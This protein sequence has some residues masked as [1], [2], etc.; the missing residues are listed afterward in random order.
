MSRQLAMVGCLVGV[1][2]VA[3]PAPVVLASRE[4][5]LIRR[6]ARVHPVELA[7]IN[8]RFLVHGSAARGWANIALEQ[9][10]ALLDPGGVPAEPPGGTLRLTDGQRFPGEALSGARPADDVLVWIQSSWLGR[11]EVPLNRIE[12][13]VFSQGASVPA[14]G[15]ADVLLLVN[16]DRV[17]GF[18]SALGDPISVEVLNDGP[19]HTIEIPL[20]RVA[21]VNM[22]TPRRRPS[23]RRVWARDGTVVDVDRL[24]LGDDGLVRLDGLPFVVE[25]GPRQVRLSAV[26]AV[27]FDPDRLVP[28]ATLE[29]LSVQGPATR[30]VVPRPRVLGERAPLALPRVEF[31]GPL[32]VRYPLPERPAYFSGEARLPV[33]ARP[34]GDCELVIRDDEREVFWARLSAQSP[35][36]TI[37]IN[38]G[39]SVL[40]IEIRQG[41]AGPIQN[42]VVLHRAMLLVERPDPS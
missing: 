30:Y 33:M 8:D 18:V 28:F 6:D 23:G 26:L 11:M 5:L 19:G 31:R 16:G 32:T 10:V 37:G 39:G 2:A 12:S 7:E 34:W 36:A 41:S 42:H 15:D 38:V 20:D 17:E 40:T 3:G 25:P 27:L 24:A 13:V 21:A 35:V 22:V 14:P 1:L 9:C 4:F 29:P